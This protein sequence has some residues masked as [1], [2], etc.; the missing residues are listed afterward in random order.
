MK[1][2]FFAHPLRVASLASACAS[3]RGTP[4]R[5]HS[6]VKGPGGG[7]DCEWFIPCALVEACAITGAEFNA[8]V[9]PPYAVNHAQH[10]TDSLFRTWFAQP[11][12][13][14]RVRPVD[15]AE[16][17]VDGDFVFPVVGRCEHHIGFRIG[18]LVWHVARPSG[19][20]AMSVAQLKLHRSRYRL[21]ELRA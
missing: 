2:Y 12:V 15:E 16:P 18:S 20:C 5:S 19:V 13:R 14:A 3:W 7:V 21:V 17:H 10:S 6:H 11:H 1:D 4:F 9:V 8:I